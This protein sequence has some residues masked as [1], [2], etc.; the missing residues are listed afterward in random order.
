M[1]SA[2]CGPPPRLT[3]TIVPDEPVRPNCPS[4][5]PSILQLL[6]VEI[7][8]LPGLQTHNVR[9]FRPMTERLS[10]A[11]TATTQCIP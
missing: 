2:I 5:A 8:S 10:S 7:S 9:A 1:K 4:D 6:A 3:P 11:F